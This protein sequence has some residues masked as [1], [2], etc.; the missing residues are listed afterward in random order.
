MTQQE[1]KKL[2]DFQLEFFFFFFKE[3]YTVAV[4]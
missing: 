1:A 2:L 3:K 4:C